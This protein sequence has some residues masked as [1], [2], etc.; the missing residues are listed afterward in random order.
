MECLK[1][2]CDGIISGEYWNTDGLEYET[3]LCNKCESEHKIT[4]N[5]ND[6]GSGEPD[7]ERFCESLE[8]LKMH[9]KQLTK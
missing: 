6:D 1:N 9:K 4:I 3:Y 8:L 5:R 7:I 2:N